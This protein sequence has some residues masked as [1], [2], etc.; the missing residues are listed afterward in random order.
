MQETAPQIGIQILTVNA[1][2]NVSL[3]RSFNR[4]KAKLTSAKIIKTIRDVI[5]A[6]PSKGKVSARNK[7]RVVTKKVEIRGVLVIALIR[8]KALGKAPCFPNP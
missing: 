1:S 2:V 6:N 3:P 5:S 4:I 7:T 8:A